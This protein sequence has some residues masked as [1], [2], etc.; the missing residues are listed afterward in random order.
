VKKWTPHGIAIVVDD[1]GAADA[2]TTAR[3][4][5][6]VDGARADAAA[7]TTNGKLC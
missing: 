4:A 1:R 2:G 5:I 7:A 6:V 3:N